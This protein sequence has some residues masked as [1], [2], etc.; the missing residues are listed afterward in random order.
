MSHIMSLT[1]QQQEKPHLFK[2][3]QNST[4]WS[5][6]GNRHSSCCS[7]GQNLQNETQSHQKGW[8]ITVHSTTSLFF[9]SF[10]LY[11]GKSLEKMF[12]QQ[13]ATCTSGPSFPR[14]RPEATAVIIVRALMRRVQAPRYPRITN[15]LRIVFT[16]RQHQRISI[17][18]QTCTLSGP[19]AALNSTLLLWQCVAI[20]TF[21]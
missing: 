14:L 18:T 17:H 5:S 16:C 9:A 2:T 19:I 21:P 13:H 7:S 12:P 20:T 1:D 6:K 8:L 3:E 10:R 15:P 11:F 4:N